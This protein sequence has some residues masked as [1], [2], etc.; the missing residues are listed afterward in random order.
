MKIPKE[1]IQN[2]AVELYPR[3]LK[4]RRH[5]HRHPELSFQEYDFSDQVRFKAWIP[6]FSGMAAG[7]TNACNK[8]YIETGFRQDN[9]NNSVLSVVN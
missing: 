1:K 3:I 4:I 8:K 9:A 6:A 5:I 2:L 7:I